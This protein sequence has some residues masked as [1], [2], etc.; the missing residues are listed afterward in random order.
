[1]PNVH[2]SSLAEGIYFNNAVSGPIQTKSTV[3]E[4]GTE[5]REHGAVLCS[6]LCSASD[7]FITSTMLLVTVQNCDAYPQAQWLPRFVPQPQAGLGSPH[8][9]DQPFRQSQAQM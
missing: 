5:S 3:R 8:S 1:M 9:P 4:G 6:G 2:T 7:A